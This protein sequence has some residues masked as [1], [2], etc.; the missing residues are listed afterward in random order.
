MQ[1]GNHVKRHVLHT[2]W[3]RRGVPLVIAHRGASASAV[4]NTASAFD[5]AAAAQADGV[6]L[7]VQRCASGQIVVF[8]DDTL[9]RLAANPARIDATPWSVLRHIELRGGER[10]LTLDEALEVIPD[11]MLINVEIKAPD[12]L[13]LPRGLVGAT[14]RAIRDRGA[15]ERGL[16][17]SFHPA[18]VSA[19]RRREPTIATGLLFH[20]HQALPLRRASL[21]RML[22]PYALHPDR[23]LVTPRTMR[24]WHRAGFAVHAWTIAA[25]T[26]YTEVARL[27]RRGVD[28]LFADDPAAARA[29][30]QRARRAP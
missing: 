29:Q 9:E 27:V 15:R 6:E 25:E 22:R 21:A 30:V 17:S 18:A 26:P 24:R 1:N 14:L 5:A 11:S 7:D 10:V 4:E 2:A 3:Q 19:T 8:H 28:A 20:A 12:R 16:V 23:S 13:P